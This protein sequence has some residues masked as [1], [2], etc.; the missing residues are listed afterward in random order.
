MKTRVCINQELLLTTSTSRTSRTQSAVWLI[1][2]PRLLFSWLNSTDDNQLLYYWW[3]KDKRVQAREDQ[4]K[5]LLTHNCGLQWP[6]GV[7]EPGGMIKRWMLANV[8]Q[9]THRHSYKPNV[10]STWKGELFTKEK[11]GWQ[12]LKSLG[13]TEKR[14]SENASISVAK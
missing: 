9:P 14:W 6:D 7:M 2:R 13:I 12:S 1:S 8:G 10:G 5:I 11:Q 3:R 4:T